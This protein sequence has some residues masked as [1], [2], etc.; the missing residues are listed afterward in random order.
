MNKF[1][2]GNFNEEP[3]DEYNLFPDASSNRTNLLEN[4]AYELPAPDGGK[5][6]NK[7]IIFNK[8]RSPELEAERLEVADRLLEEEEKK[9]VIEE[10]VQDEVDN[11]QTGRRFSD[12]FIGGYGNAVSGGLRLM[13]NDEGA[14]QIQASL[15]T[16]QIQMNQRKLMQMARENSPGQADILEEELEQTFVGDLA[17]GAGQLVGQVGAVGTASALT[18]PYGGGAMLTGLVVGNNFEGNYNRSVE[19]DG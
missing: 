12:G 10:A 17:T 3:V 19:E 5:M 13:G 6:A 9:R 18:G 8:A 1:D 4:F 2:F 14:D 15:R 11:F 7:G 16:P